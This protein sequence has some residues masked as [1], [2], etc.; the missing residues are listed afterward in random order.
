MTVEKV[1]DLQKELDHE[2]GFRVLLI[3][4]CQAYE[5]LQTLWAGELFSLE[6]IQIIFLSDSTK[7][8]SEKKKKRA[9]ACCCIEVF[10]GSDIINIPM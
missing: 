9:K 3:L 5:V 4:L 10:P 1:F 8:F 7:F 2:K 6:C